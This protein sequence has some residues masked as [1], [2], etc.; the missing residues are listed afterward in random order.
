MKT[1][2]FR[3]LAGI[4][5]Q[6]GKAIQPGLIYRTGNLSHIDE[7][8]AGTIINTSNIT[9][10]VDFRSK[11]EVTRFGGPDHFT[12]NGVEWVNLDVNSMQPD[13]VKIKRPQP[14]DWA[15]FYHNLFERNLHVWKSFITLIAETEK[16]MAY[17]CLFGKDR[18][19][20][21]TALLLD[22]LG[23]HHDHITSNF[24][25]TTENVQHLHKHFLHLWKNHELTEE[26]VFHHY[27]TAHPEAI[28]GFLTYVRDD[29]L[30]DEAHEFNQ[31]LSPKL[32]DRLKKKLLI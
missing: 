32:L 2:N 25:E 4:P 12:K 21:A 17:G 3:D 19:G 9:L 30:A 1:I 23:V 27:A 31:H 16:P 11:D 24:A 13:F 29:S 28:S 18:T 22:A 5:T 6:E 7:E 26:E 8:M 10:Y 20:I 15:K 14:A